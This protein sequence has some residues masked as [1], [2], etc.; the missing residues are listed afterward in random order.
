MERIQLK[1]FDEFLNEETSSQ[2]LPE[3]FKRTIYRLPT[4]EEI[5]EVNS[6]NLSSRQIVNGFSYTMIGRG[7]KSKENTDMIV[8]SIELLCKL[9]PDNTEYKKALEIVNNGEKNA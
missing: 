9:Y 1:T 3:I 4:E 5:G 7:I 6:H 8:K 2:S